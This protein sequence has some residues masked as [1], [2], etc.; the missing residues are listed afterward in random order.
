MK[1]VKV[2]ELFGSVPDWEYKGEPY[3][4]TYN[5]ELYMPFEVA[6][7]IGYIICDESIEEVNYET[8]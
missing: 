3:V 8:I 7:D 1:A 2:E 4:F 6:Y 5:N